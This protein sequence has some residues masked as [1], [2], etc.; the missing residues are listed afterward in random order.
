MSAHVR[1]W[2]KRGHSVPGNDDGRQPGRSACPPFHHCRACAP[3]PAL[4]LRPRTC[5]ATSS[6]RCSCSSLSC[7]CLAR[8]TSSVRRR[9]VAVRHDG[10][11]AQGGGWKTA[12]HCT[13]PH[14]HS[15]CRS[16]CLPACLPPCLR[17]AIAA[18]EAAAGDE[19]AVG[20]GGPAECNQGML[21]CRQ[22]PSSSSSSSAAMH[23]ARAVDQIPDIPRSIE[24]L[25]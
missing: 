16:S 4:S 9:L 3:P 20:I 25:G 8:P 11:E 19:R 15:G 23:C 22:K 13:C 2:V 14:Q 1:V 6:P 17:P 5:L 10:S 7:W 21:C 12:Q 18:A 24:W